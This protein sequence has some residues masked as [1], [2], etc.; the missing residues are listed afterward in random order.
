MKE[1]ANLGAFSK[2][3]EKVTAQYTNR[4][5]KALDFIGQRIEDKAKEAIGHLQAG[6]GG[7]QSWPELAEA[8]KTDKEKKGFVFN[9]Q[10]NPLYRTGELKESIHHVVAVLNSEFG[11]VF[12]GSPL[13]IALFQEMG[14]KTIP[15][16][17]FLGLTM[18]KEKEQIQYIL[19]LFLHN[20]I[21]N[22]YA[23]LRIKE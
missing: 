12:V 5:H 15:A 2:Q 9:E 20:W 4:E 17:S 21:I 23:S 18:F 6:G 3:L 7:F 1:F 13:D 19:G 11:R 10:Y 8:T 16:R 22:T 14:T